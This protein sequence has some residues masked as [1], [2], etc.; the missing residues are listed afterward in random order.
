V[1]DAGL[2]CCSFSGI[3]RTTTVMKVRCAQVAVPG[4]LLHIFELGAVLEC[5]GDGGAHQG[6][7]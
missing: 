7:E 6:A 3:D 2:H 1:I 4:D 5:R